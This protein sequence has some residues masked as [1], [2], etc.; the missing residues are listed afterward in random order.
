MGDV[1]WLAGSKGMLPGLVMAGS[2]RGS[3]VVS[4]LDGLLM[5]AIT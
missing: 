5:H 2:A 4:Q 3:T 1:G